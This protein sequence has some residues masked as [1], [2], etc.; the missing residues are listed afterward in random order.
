MKSDKTENLDFGKEFTLELG[1]EVNGDVEWIMIGHFWG[2]RL[3]QTMRD[4]MELV[5]YDKMTRFDRDVSDFIALQSFPTT[6]ETLYNNLCQFCVIDVTAGDEIADVMSRTVAN[7]DD[8]DVSSCRDL[9]ALIAEAN[10]CYAKILN[11]GSIQLK[12]FDDCTSD[13]E[14]LRDNCYSYQLSKLEKSYSKKWAILEDKKWKEVESVQYSEFDNNN[15]PFDFTNIRFV[16]DDPWKEIVQPPNDEL[17]DHKLWANV[18][19]AQW[20]NVESMKWKDFELADDI[21]GGVYSIRNNPFL[22]YDTD[23]EIKAHLQLILDR[24]Y[25]FHLYYVATVSM[26]GNWLIEPGDIVTLEIS[27][28][29]FTTYPI[30]NRI[31]YWNGA[32]KC[33]Y[34]T[35]RSLSAG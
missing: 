29:V 6:L 32:C 25:T 7:L 13:Q 19:N 2:N 4:T 16:W 12:W 11:D 31:L 24:L 14:L 17:Y 35:T 3:V 23:D 15:N 28:G 8:A 26:V 21:S 20:E 5:A 30:F 18:E 27:D 1:V 9:L 34:E 22:K 33:S 10:G